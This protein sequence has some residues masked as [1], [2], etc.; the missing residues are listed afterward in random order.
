MPGNEHAVPG[1]I[2]KEKW[3]PCSPEPMSSV[4]ITYP[5]SLIRWENHQNGIYH[6]KLTLINIGGPPKIK[7]LFSH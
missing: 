1:T 3:Y 2:E 4:A 6:V 7:W 5:P